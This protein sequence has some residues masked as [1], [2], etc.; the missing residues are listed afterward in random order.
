MEFFEK[1]PELKQAVDQI[2]GGYFSPEDSNMFIDIVNTIKYQDRYESK[3][4]DGT[5]GFVIGLLAVL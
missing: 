2:G 3:W 4:K 5:S 1:Q